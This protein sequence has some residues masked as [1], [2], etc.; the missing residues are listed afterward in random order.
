MYG[1]MSGVAEVTA[2]GN[3]QHEDIGWRA[4]RWCV[5]ENTVIPANTLL[6]PTCNNKNTNACSVCPSDQ[7]NLG[8]K[9]TN[10]IIRRSIWPAG[11]Q[12]LALT[13]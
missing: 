3:Q 8:R 5:H 6:G 11:V 12:K 10:Q 2:C 4:D 13:A 7:R 1:H 9:K